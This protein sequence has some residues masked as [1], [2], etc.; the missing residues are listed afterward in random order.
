MK[1]NWD[2]AI[3]A[4]IGF[5]LGA[6]VASFIAAHVKT[7]E[8]CESVCDTKYSWYEDGRCICAEEKKASE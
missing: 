8:V 2:E 3:V 1:W 7:K 6:T 4:M 5:I